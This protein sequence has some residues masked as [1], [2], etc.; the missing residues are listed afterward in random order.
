MSAEQSTR[1]PERPFSVKPRLVLVDSAS[2]VTL[3]DKIIAINTSPKG[4]V[5]ATELHLVQTAVRLIQAAKDREIPQALI[6]PAERIEPN[7]KDSILA[8]AGDRNI[9]DNA[10]TIIINP[11]T[12]E[13]NIGP[14][15]IQFKSLNNWRM[16]LN[17]ATHYGQDLRS[18]DFEGLISR[19]IK[20][21]AHALV[22]LRAFL[23]PHSSLI[24]KTSVGTRTA[25][26]KLD[27]NVEFL[28]EPPDNIATTIIKKRKK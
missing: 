18:G 10:P 21:P 26:W 2:P 1:V 11:I 7:K 14:D 15:S 22:V 8:T 6:E 12:G 13:I 16:F 17:F 5:S 4:F 28:H 20:S 23:E 9:S 19:G 3:K 24:K 27:A 25:R